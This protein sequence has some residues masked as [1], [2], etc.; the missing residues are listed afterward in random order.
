MIVGYVVKKTGEYF[1]ACLAEWSDNNFLY[2][3]GYGELVPSEYD[4]V[5][6]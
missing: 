2:L 5:T 1:H 3:T 4:V 6:I